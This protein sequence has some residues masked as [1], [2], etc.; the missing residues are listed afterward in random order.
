MN[1]LVLENPRVPSGGLDG[2]RFRMLIQ[3]GD[4]HFSSSWHHGRKSSQTQTTLVEIDFFVL[5][6]CDFWI[7]DDVERHRYAF[8]FR[9]L[10][11]G[12]GVQQFFSIFNHRQLQRQPDLRCR[13]TDTWSVAHRIEHIPNESPYLFANDLFP[14]QWAR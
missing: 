5:E 14:R 11:G 7:D 10:L 4:A 9:K 3:I 6:G 12:Q 8:P 1:N 2:S 13:Q